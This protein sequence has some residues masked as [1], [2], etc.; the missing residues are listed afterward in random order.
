[1]KILHLTYDMRI[2]GTEMVIKNIIEGADSEAFDMSIFCIEEPV[3]PWGQALRATGIPVISTRR[4]EGFDFA[5]IQR[6][7]RHLREELIDLIH[8]HQ[9]TPWVYG[10]LAAFGLK[11]KVI[12]TEHGRFYPD[13][14]SWKRKAVNPFLCLITD[15]I[16]SISEATKKALVEYEN[17]PAKR[18]ETIYNGIKPLEVDSQS[19]TELK[20][21]LSFDD[22]TKV[23]GSV[24]R[25]DPIKN[26]PMMLRAFRIVLDKYPETRLLLVGDGEERENIEKLILDM[27]LEGKVILPGYQTVAKD[28][29]AV[30]DI[31]L[32]TS[33]SEGT[34]MTLLEAMSL[35][36]PCVVT[37]V[38]GNPEVITHDE[39]GFVVKSDNAEEFAA[40]IVKLLEADNLNQKFSAQASERFEL[41]FKDSRMNANYEGCYRQ[42]G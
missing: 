20:K 36:K 10:C 19:I 28:Y 24:A 30:M 31:F 8:C 42:Y 12:F 6:I 16:T 2:G 1:M 35:G 22:S 14:S 32:L 15:K 5:L 34:S 4:Q 23:L 7:R 3:G 17:I 33:F 40:A 13:L 27:G 21:A 39:N 26:H 25:F 29:I 37:D 18:I 11:T 41:Q 9:Y 38:G